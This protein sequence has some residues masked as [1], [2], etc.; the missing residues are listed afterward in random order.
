VDSLC[1]YSSHYPWSQSLANSQFWL[2]ATIL[3]SQQQ[4]TSSGNGTL[5]RSDV[6]FNPVRLEDHGVYTCSILGSQ[7]SVTLTVVLFVN[8][9][10]DI[11]MHALLAKYILS[12]E[13]H[14]SWPNLLMLSLLQQQI[15][16]DTF[17]L[18]HDSHL[19]IIV[20]LSDCYVHKYITVYTCT[21]TATYKIHNQRY[22]KHAHSG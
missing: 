20:A 5:W 4:K 2:M 12:H 9:G 6:I 15:R 21:Y 22:K 13:L 7:P 14:H 10:E 8:T 11:S 17:R 1:I 3:L 19:Q 18:T 16:M